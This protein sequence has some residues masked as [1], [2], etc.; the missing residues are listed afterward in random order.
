MSAKFNL[1]TAIASAIAISDV[2]RLSTIY[3]E[4]IVKKKVDYSTASSKDINSRIL[5]AAG[6]FAKDDISGGF[7]ISAK[8]WAKDKSRLANI[9]TDENFSRI[10]GWLSMQMLE[11]I[12]EEFL[13]ISVVRIHTNLEGKSDYIVMPFIKAE[14]DFAIKGDRIVLYCEINHLD[15]AAA[16][17][18]STT[19]HA[20]LEKLVSG[21]MA[22][23]FTKDEGSHEKPSKYR[24]NDST[25]AIF[26]CTCGDT[27]FK[28][29]VDVESEEITRDLNRIAAI[30]SFYTVSS[31][32]DTL[33]INN[34][35]DKTLVKEIMK[36][37]T[38]KNV[39]SDSVTVNGN[40]FLFGSF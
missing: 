19:Y 34:V 24:S 1:A 16:L 23:G 29:R 18:L 4:S 7:V 30:S 25:V 35:A 33:D 3:G 37:E 5:V 15:L 27:T 22:L 20:E 14:K 26:G 8:Q 28:F 38:V 36:N 2:I 12:E 21:I 31:D 32:F 10:E 9:L 17:Q 40:Q 39:S 11:G 13:S 6:K